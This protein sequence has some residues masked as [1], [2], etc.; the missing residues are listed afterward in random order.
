MTASEAQRVRYG[1]ALVAGGALL[2]YLLRASGPPKRREV[3]P[4]DEPSLTQWANQAGQMV[5]L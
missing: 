4:V 1:F 2:L 3:I 5:F